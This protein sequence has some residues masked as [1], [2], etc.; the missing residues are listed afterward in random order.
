MIDLIGF[1]TGVTIYTYL[2]LFI[3]A[4]F[5]IIC[6]EATIEWSSRGRIKCGS[7]IMDWLDKHLGVDE[8][9]VGS[10]FFCSLFVAGITTTYVLYSA[11]CTEDD[12]YTYVGMVTDVAQWAAPILGWIASFFIVVMSSALFLRKMFDMFFGI[13]DKIDSLEN[14]DV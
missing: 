6:A 10:S 13:K 5:F 2:L 12:P 14:K 9:F 8:D 1:W 4:V 7:W 3:P 11:A